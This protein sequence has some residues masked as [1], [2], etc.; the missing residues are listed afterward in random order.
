MVKGDIGPTDVNATA[1]KD[2]EIQRLSLA[3]EMTEANEANAVFPAERIARV[4]LHLLNG[5]I[6]SSDWHHSK[7]DPGHPPS[8][9]EFREAPSVRRRNYRTHPRQRH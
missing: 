1:L 7:W 8:A 2:P 3:T 6:L 4:D 9:Q 5:D